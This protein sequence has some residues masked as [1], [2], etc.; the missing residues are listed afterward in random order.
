MMIS[1]VI[2]KNFRGSVYVIQDSKVLCEKVTGFADLA[3]EI[4]NRN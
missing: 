1:E 3:N 2:D 4:P